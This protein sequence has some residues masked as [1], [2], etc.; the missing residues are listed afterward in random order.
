MAHQITGIDHVRIAVANAAAA[1]RAF[2]RLGF[3]LSPPWQD[4]GSGSLSHSLAFGADHVELA[5]SGGTGAASQRLDRFLAGAAG[6][7]TA[8]GLGSR[9]IQMSTESLRRAAVDV[10]PPSR[11]VR[12]LL[13]FDETEARSAELWSVSMLE[14]P[15]E[16]TP[17]LSADLCD[18]PTPAIIRRPEWLVHPNTAMGIVSLSVVLDNPETAINSYNRLFGPAACT[19]T[20]SL[21]TVHTGHGLIFLVT[22]DGFDD[23]HPSLAVRLP[24][25]PAMAVLTIGVADL[26]KAAAVLAANGVAAVRRGGHLG[27]PEEEALGIGL[28]FVEM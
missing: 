8:V 17:G 26:A 13:P 5:A 3:F 23:L 21:V 18:F 1:Y 19:P 11:R 14:L 16:L 10:R 22:A 6:K 15:D 27:I 28:E 9:D 20:D 7:L 2:S 4:D 12:R 25:P 24:P